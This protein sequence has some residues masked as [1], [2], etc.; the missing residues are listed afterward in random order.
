MHAFC[1]IKP[2]SCFCVSLSAF[3]GALFYLQLY[4]FLCARCSVN[5]FVYVMFSSIAVSLRLMQC[6]S[7]SFILVITGRNCYAGNTI[8]QA[9]KSVKI[10]DHTTCHCPTRF[11]FGMTAQR[12]VCAIRVDSVTVK[13]V[14]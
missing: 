2:N 9:G 6:L 7:S 8:I 11:G 4:R 12:A 5:L 13:S 1:K 10:D 3:L 14:N